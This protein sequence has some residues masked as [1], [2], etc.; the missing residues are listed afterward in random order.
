[1]LVELGVVVLV[2]LRST[3]RLLDR[4]TFWVLHDL[5]VVHR[6][7]WW[8]RLLVRIMKSI[9]GTGLLKVLA[10]TDDFPDVF[11]RECI[12]SLKVSLAQLG[13]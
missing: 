11:I 13:L 10:L 4:L 5:D 3:G 8:V 1:M 2:L 6:L 12:P 7:H 9:N